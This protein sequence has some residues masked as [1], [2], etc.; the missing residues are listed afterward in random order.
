MAAKTDTSA[1]TEKPTE[2]KHAPT[3]GPADI[4]ENAFLM[5]LGVLELTR[6]RAK[7]IADDLIARGK[8]TRADARKVADKL[9]AMAEEQQKTVSKMVAEQTAKVVQ[10]AGVASKKDLD[11]LRAE[12][13]ELKKLLA[14]KAP[15]KRAPAKKAPAQTT[16]KAAG[17]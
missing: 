8:V 11:A 15:A 1:K 14:K 5:G 4:A 6:E 2:S 17:A 16:K 9:G 12:V 13:A 10:T 3:Y 7:E